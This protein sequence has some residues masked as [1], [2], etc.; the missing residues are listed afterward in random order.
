MENIQGDERDIIILSVTYGKKKS[1][2]F[3]Q[4]FG[5]LNH[6]KGYK[7]LNV[8]ITR[9]K[10]KIYVCNSIPVEVFEAYKEALAAEG[11]NNRRAVLYAYLSYCR[12]VSRGNDAARLEILA[13]LDRY[14]HKQ[15]EGGTSHHNLFKEQLFA[16]LK[17]QHPDKDIFL[18]Y[19]FG[20]YTIDILLKPR[21][22]KPIA[23]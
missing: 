13:E 15:N 18:D 7:L 2:K 9:A 10:E 23:I 11:A 14:G 21:K 8:I 6:T 20:G 5:P 1:G 4:S 3:V 19:H 22:G 17:A 16:Q 12:A